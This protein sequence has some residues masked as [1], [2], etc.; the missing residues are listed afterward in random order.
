ALCLAAAAVLL[1]ALLQRGG[2]RTLGFEQARAAGDREMAVQLQTFA[3][4]QGL[5]R[6]AGRDGEARAALQR[7]CDEQHR[8]TRALMR[9]SLPLEL[10]FAAAVQ[11]VFVAMLIGGAWAVAAGR[12]DAATAVAVL[13]LLVRFIEPLAQLTQLDQA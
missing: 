7:A 8:R 5:L 4:H 10:G 11:G 2:A 9:R 1:F 12:L 13:V 6:F 3:A